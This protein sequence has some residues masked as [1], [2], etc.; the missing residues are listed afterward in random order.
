MK[1]VCCECNNPVK[2][3][4]CSLET[5]K[6]KKGVLPHLVATNSCAM[7][8]GVNARWVRAQ[9]SVV[10]QRSASDNT[11]ITKLLWC[12]E[13]FERHEALM[14][15]KWAHDLHAEL[16]AVVAQLRNG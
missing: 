8:S 16:N 14:I 4:C 12:I 11:A 7:L 2:Q 9:K 6:L 13:E 3:P 10:A 1:W 15:D 5:A